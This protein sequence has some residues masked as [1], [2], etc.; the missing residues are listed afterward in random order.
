[1]AM[2]KKII[3]LTFATCTLSFIFL[4]MQV[5]SGN[6]IVKYNDIINN[7]LNPVNKDYMDHIANLE[8]YYSQQIKE[9]QNEIKNLG[10]EKDKYASKCTD[11][12]YELMKNVAI[13]NSNINA[14]NLKVAELGA[15]YNYYRQQIDAI[16]FVNN[17]LNDCTGECF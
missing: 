2:C 9:L 12:Y 14:I 1:M 3:S 5:W 15:G 17:F 11:A 7:I 13:C 16:E 8:M 6:I 10:A 4:V